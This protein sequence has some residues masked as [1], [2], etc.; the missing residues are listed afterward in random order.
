MLQ[1]NVAQLRGAP[2]GDARSRVPPIEDSSDEAAALG[3]TK[4]IKPEIIAEDEEIQKL[5]LQLKQMRKEK[6]EQIKE[7]NAV[8]SKRLQELS[9]K[10]QAEMKEK[11]EKKRKQKTEAQEQKPQKRR[12][13]ADK[14]AIP[15]K[16]SEVTEEVFSGGS[17]GEVLNR[18]NTKR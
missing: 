12:R 9:D 11:A 6:E 2:A 17:L 8:E 16:A 3:P 1:E 7:A 18:R 5:Q 4:K 10:H 15:S 13:K 14:Q